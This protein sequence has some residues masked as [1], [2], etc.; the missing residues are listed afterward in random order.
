MSE[1]KLIRKKAK[2]ASAINFMYNFCL[3]VQPSCVRCFCGIKRIT[4]LYSWHL[5]SLLYYQTVSSTV[6]HSSSDCRYSLTHATDTLCLSVKNS[7]YWQ[8]SLL[9]NTMFL[10][11]NYHTGQSF[12]FVLI[13]HSHELPNI[14]LWYWWHALAETLQFCKEHR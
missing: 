13:I 3:K 8:K 14:Q 5:I 10:F 6:C 11:S 2:L 4:F 12:R 9:Q 7:Q 1:I